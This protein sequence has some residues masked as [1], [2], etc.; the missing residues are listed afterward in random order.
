[1]CRVQGD[2][3]M[4]GLLVLAAVLGTLVAAPAGAAQPYGGCAEAWQAPHSKGATVCRDRGWQINLHGTR[5]DHPRG[6]VVSPHAVLR[7]LN[8]PNCKYED[9]GENQPCAWNLQGVQ[10]NGV[11]L[12]YWV[13]REDRSRYVWR[14]PAR[15]GWKAVSHRIA[16]SLADY[17]DARWERWRYDSRHADGVLHLR[18]PNGRHRTIR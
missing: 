11:G 18:A 14:H 2:A 13:D 1:M 16:E 3:A 6:T 5:Q 17:G 4:K 8:L 9:G 7:Y 15:H 10:G 12:A